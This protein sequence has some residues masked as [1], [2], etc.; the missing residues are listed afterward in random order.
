MP[1]YIYIFFFSITR[2]GLDTLGISRNTKRHDIFCFCRGGVFRGRGVALPP[3]NP[4]GDNDSDTGNVA[5]N[6]SLA[7]FL[8]LSDHIPTRDTGLGVPLDTQDRQPRQ[9]KSSQSNL[10]FASLF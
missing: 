1:I 9:A 6:D 8:E 3:L 10:Y 2:K 7:S 5:D 4:G